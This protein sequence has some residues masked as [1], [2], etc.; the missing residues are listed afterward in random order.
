LIKRAIITGDVNR[1]LSLQESNIVR[2]HSLLSDTLSAVFDRVELISTGE[3][4]EDVNK[5]G[6]S[7]DYDGR[8][9]HPIL[10]EDLSDA[11]VISFEAPKSLLRELDCAGVPY[12]DFRI[13]PYRFLDDIVFNV[14]PAF[15]VQM[16]GK[17]PKS[18]LCRSHKSEK[19]YSILVGQCNYDASLWNCRRFHTVSEYVDA[20][21]EKTNFP[22]YY[23]PHPL[24]TDDDILS[25]LNVIDKPIYEILTDKCLVSVIGLSSSVLDE[26]EHLKIP[27][28]RFIPKY[29]HFNAYRPVSTATLLSPGLWHLF[30]KK[31]SLGANF[32]RD[33]FN[34]Y[35]GFE[36]K[37]QSI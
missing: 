20:A 2:F 30:Y 17:L 13:S 29:E 23:K 1:P 6:Q 7:L 37:P 24:F 36:K 25:A 5:W 10:Q 34:S 16:S 8:S 19:M 3:L 31:Q 32:L 4:W 35:W 28:V 14:S 11:I 18:Q 26:A 12:R 9:I 33:H 22:L 27:T 15:P 21:L